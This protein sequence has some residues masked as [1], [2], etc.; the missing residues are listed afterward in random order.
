[1]R[2]KGKE[3]NSFRWRIEPCV[4]SAAAIVSNFLGMTASG[5]AMSW[6]SRLWRKPPTLPREVATA[7]LTLPGW[8]EGTPVRN[9]RIWRDADGDI[10]SFAVTEEPFANYEESDEEKV[11]NWC[12]ELS[13]SNGGGLIEAHKLDG[14][15]R[16]IY[17][18]LQIPAYVYTGQ[19]ITAV[20][21]N[22]FVW[23]MVAGE[24]GI[25]GLREPLRPPS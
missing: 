1:M 16:L 14:A 21:E 22:W 24:H 6:L 4:D 19:F 2:D 7:R 3:E 12:R 11:R 25:T 13:Q 8:S 20:R 10:L 9:M 18:R 17:K 23:T 5:G 15:I